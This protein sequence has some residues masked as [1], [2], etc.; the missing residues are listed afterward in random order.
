MKIRLGYLIKTPSDQK[1]VQWKWLFKLKE[2]QNDSDP[3]KYNATPVAKEFTHG[4]GIDFNEI[5]SYVVLKFKP[6]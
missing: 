2:G 6:Y 3:L 1:L 5:F 4:V